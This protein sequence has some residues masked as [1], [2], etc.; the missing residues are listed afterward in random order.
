MYLPAA[1]LKTAGD[2]NEGFFCT[3]FIEFCDDHHQISGGPSGC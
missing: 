1:C 3:A 2:P